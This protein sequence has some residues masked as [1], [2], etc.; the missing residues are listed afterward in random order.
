MIHG[1]DHI[2]F[3]M[4]LVHVPVGFCY[5]F[6]RIALINYRPEFFRFQQSFI[7]VRNSVFS[8]DMPKMNLGPPHALVVGVNK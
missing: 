5:L 2:P 1:D 7:K 4:A 8:T 3:F 6:Q